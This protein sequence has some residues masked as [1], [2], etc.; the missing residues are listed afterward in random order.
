MKKYPNK[1]QVASF[2]PEHVKLTKE[3]RE[4]TRERTNFTNL[5]VEKLP[6]SYQEKDVLEL[7]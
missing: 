4:K 6:F 2:D 5:Y 3:E 1:L 7:F